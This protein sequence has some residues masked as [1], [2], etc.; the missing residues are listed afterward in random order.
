MRRPLFSP[1]FALSVAGLVAIPVLV[2]SAEDRKL[3]PEQLEVLSNGGDL[4]GEEDQRPKNLP[5]LTKGEPAGEM[6]KWDVWHLGPTGI[7]GFMVGGSR[8]ALVGG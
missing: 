7:I 4:R 6:Q 5:D 8:G 3:T 2:A 1:A